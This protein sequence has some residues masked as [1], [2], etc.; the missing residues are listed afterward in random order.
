MTRPLHELVGLP[1]ATPPEELRYASEQRLRAAFERASRGD[2]NAHRE[3][4]GLRLAYLNWAY[5][6]SEVGPAGA[7]SHKRSEAIVLLP[8]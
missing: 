8:A 7:S 5:T 4:V 6:T 2:K 1:P 3:L